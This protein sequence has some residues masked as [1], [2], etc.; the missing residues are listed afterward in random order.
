MGGPSGENTMV[1]HEETE[2]SKLVSVA[3]SAQFV[4]A[5]ALTLGRSDITPILCLIGFYAVQERKRNATR[6]YLLFL[7]CSV[8]LDVA[9]LC[10]YNDFIY[11]P[12][13]RPNT[14]EARVNGL[15]KFVFIFSVILLL[16]KVV[17]VYLV[18]KFFL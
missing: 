6:T 1:K 11:D 8:F 12:R 10:I 7:V 14:P 4:I 16:I 15:L 5:M 9:W 17:S 18:Y 13:V 2:N 3:L